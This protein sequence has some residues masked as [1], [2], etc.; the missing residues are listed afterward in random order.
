MSEIL[1]KLP[2]GS[3]RKLPK[4]ASAMDLAQNIS[5]QLAK[6]IVVALVNGQLQDLA[7]PLK[8]GDQVVLLDAKS[9]EAHEVIS[10][11]CEHVLAAAVVELFPGAQVSMGP[12]SHA[13]GFYYDFDI[14]RPFSEEDLANIEKKMAGLIKEG[15]SFKKSWQSKSEAK[16]LFQALGQKYKPEILDWIEGDQVTLYESAH[17]TDL[18]RGPHLPSSS[19]IKAF[20]ILGVSGSY[21][22]GDSSREMLQRISGVAFSNPVELEEYLFRIEEAKRRDHRKLGPRHGLFFVSEKFNSWNDGKAITSEARLVVNLS[23]K[24]AAESHVNDVVAKLEELLSAIQEKLPSKALALKGMNMVPSDDHPEKAVADLRIF[25]CLGDASA[26][27]DVMDLVAAFNQASHGHE[28]KSHFE[29]HAQEEIGPGLVMWLPEGGRLR[30][31]VEDFARKRHFDNGYDMVYSPH[32][33]KSDLWRISGHLGFYQDSMFAPMNIDGNEYILK[34]MNCPFHALMYKFKPRSYRDLPIRLAEFGTVY[35]Y[36]MA[37]VLHGLMRVRGFTQDD[38][39]LFCRWDQLDDEL[40]RVLV[41]VLSMLKAFGFSDFEVNISTRPEKYVG[42][43]SNWERAESSLKAAVART[44]LE[45]KVDEGGGAFYGPKIDIKLKDC[46]NRMW[47]CSTVQ[48]D[49]NNPERFDL[50]FINNSGEKERPVMLHR[51]LFGSIERFIGILIEHYAGA[52]PAWLAPEQVRIVTVSDRHNEHAFTVLRALKD[53]GIRA[54]F[55]ESHDKLGAKIRDAQMDKIPMMVVIGDKEVSELG[56]TLRLRSQE[57][58]GFFALADLVS[59]IK[60]ECEPPTSAK[61]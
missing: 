59:T 28:V 35:R 51:A 3:E 24:L 61:F 30:S 20:K 40:D 7:D 53:A 41:F 13:E 49:F 10:H 45:F 52:F 14:G 38:A 27:K 47:Q 23:R 34:P 31:L 22:R 43:L 60:L 57:D 15:I 18:C 1:I 12:K 56:A 42:E 11:S 46:L 8:D 6:R 44:G 5:P 48:L 58:K 16:K 33:A 36:E 39:H 19:F 54:D 21:W 26:R 29:T 25:A 55:K 50:N 4:G 32:I 2:D 17:F 9:K 37:G